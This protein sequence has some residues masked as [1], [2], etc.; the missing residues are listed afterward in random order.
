MCSKGQRACKEKSRIQGGAGTGTGLC[1]HAGLPELSE[2]KPR[3]PNLH[4][5]QVILWLLRVQGEAES[6]L[7]ELQRHRSLQPCRAARAD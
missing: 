6:A 2:W 1:S 5:Q 3:D 7:G 4:E